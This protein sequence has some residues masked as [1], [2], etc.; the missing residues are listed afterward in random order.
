VFTT[1][2]QGRTFFHTVRRGETL[3]SIGTRYGVTPGELRAWNDMSQSTIKAGR[4]LRVTSDVVRPT[5][6]RGTARSAAATGGA[7]QLSSPKSGGT[8]VSNAASAPEHARPA[9]APIKSRGASGAGASVP[10]A[11]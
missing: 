11:R 3:T 4:Q 8:P 5:S 7:K 9:A 2:P 1:V 10:R 6:T